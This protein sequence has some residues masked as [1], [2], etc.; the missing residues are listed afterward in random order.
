MK[1]PHVETLA[2]S[3]SIQNQLKRERRC[4]Y[5]TRNH[6]SAREAQREYFK[7]LVRAKVFWM[8]VPEP[9]QPEQLTRGT[10]NQSAP[11]HLKEQ[12]EKRDDV[13]PTI[14]EVAFKSFCKWLCSRTEKE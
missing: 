7:T 10:T 3:L 9:R 12:P 5:K 14:R 2:S 4:V 11:A 8:G 1:H 6:E 13:P